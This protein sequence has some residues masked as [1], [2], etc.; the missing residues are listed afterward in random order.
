MKERRMKRG[1]FLAAVVMVC[2]GCANMQVAHFALTGNTYRTRTKTEKR[3]ACLID[4]EYLESKFVEFFSVNYDVAA[5]KSER[6]AFVAKVKEKIKGSLP[7]N[8][9]YLETFPDKGASYDAVVVVMPVLRI[10]VMEEGGRVEVIAVIRGRVYDGTGTRTSTISARASADQS[11]AGKFKYI[12]AMEYY[13]TFLWDP[14]LV[15]VITRAM[16]Q[17]FDSSLKDFAGRIAQVG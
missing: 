7:A 6:Q 3:V 15:D 8:Y 9:T 4:T 16:N 12:G 14:A 13:K 1:W 17:A 5:L 11:Y 10:S 2:V